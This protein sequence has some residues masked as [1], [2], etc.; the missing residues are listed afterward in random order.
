MARQEILNELHQI[1]SNAA[2]AK[3]P[4]ETDENAVNGLMAD[5]I[6]SDG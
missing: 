6:L 4:V 5:E 1:G 3:L 2:I